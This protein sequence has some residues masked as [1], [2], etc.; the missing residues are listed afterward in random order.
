[1]LVLGL[2]VVTMS[3]GPLTDGAANHPASAA[4]GF[5]AGGS[6]PQDRVSELPRL[7]T[8][9]DVGQAYLEILAARPPHPRTLRAAKDSGCG[10][11]LPSGLRPGTTSVRSIVSGGTTRVYRLHVPAGSTATTPLP[12]VLNFHG[13]YGTAIEQEQYSGL[14]PVSDREDFLLLTPDGTGDPTGWSAGA[15]PPNGVD[16]V[17]L[18]NDLLDTVERELCVDAGRVYATG[19]S[20]G[21][22]MSSR[23]A[24]EMSDRIAAFAPVGGVDF[25][26]SG[27]GAP[28]PML[29]FHGTDDEVVPLRGGQVRG[30]MY[31]GADVAMDAWAAQNGCLAA[32]ART[33]PLGR[34]VA[35]TSY[36]GCQAEA[37]MVFVQGGGHTWPGARDNPGLGSTTHDISAAE[38]IW[39]FFAAN[40]IQ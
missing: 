28:V 31:A 36:Q 20:N 29:A 16:D 33:V 11:P 22:F 10:R 25:P 15:T 30:W 23:L 5:D 14:L 19:F 7:A 39:T 6:G 37:S 27:C 4:A 35:R 17:R 18:V 40:A 12:V 8:H 34:T 32:N 13:R 2:A 21:A 38:L 1:M 3:C 9:T 24:C 26:A